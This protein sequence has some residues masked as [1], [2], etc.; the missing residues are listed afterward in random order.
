L[1]NLKNVGATVGIGGEIAP[2]VP[3]GYAPVSFVA[4]IR[5]NRE[6]K[7]QIYLTGLL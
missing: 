7:V 6:W 3:L 4:F 5:K 2:L 1:I